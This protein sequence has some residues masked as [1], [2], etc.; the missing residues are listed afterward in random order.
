VVGWIGCGDVEGGGVGGG[1]GAHF[2]FRC[3]GSLFVGRW[4]DLGVS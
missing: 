1:S 4:G 2:E 3:G